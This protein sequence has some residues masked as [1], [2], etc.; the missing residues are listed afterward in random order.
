MKSKNHETLTE[1]EDDDIEDEDDHGTN[2]NK[3]RAR[4]RTVTLEDKV[5]EHSRYSK[6]TWSKINDV[7]LSKQVAAKLEE[8]E[9]EFEH[10]NPTQSASDQDHLLTLTK[11]Q[12]EKLISD[13][14]HAL[15][16]VSHD[17]AKVPGLRRMDD[18]SKQD[19]Q[20][21]TRQS[22]SRTDYRNQITTPSHTSKGNVKTNTDSSKSKTAS[23]ERPTDAK[24]IEKLKSI[25]DANSRGKA[26]SVQPSRQPSRCTSRHAS[27]PATRMQIHRTYHQQQTKGKQYSQSR[28]ATRMTYHP[29][30]ALSN[31]GNLGSLDESTYWN[32]L[33]QE[34][35]KTAKKPGSGGN[36][37]SVATA[38]GVMNSTEKKSLDLVRFQKSLKVSSGWSEDLSQVVLNKKREGAYGKEAFSGTD[39]IAQAI[40]LAMK[41][42]KPRES[43]MR[44]LT[45]AG[46][47]GVSKAVHQS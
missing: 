8:K 37:T 32:E 22:K 19:R 29:N 20:V 18:T 3:V 12:K 28:P 40:S 30:R 41:F 24:K 45:G 4:E 25:Y 43:L 5:T 23:K 14:A 7:H 46:Q 47:G 42:R 6:R 26:K 38:F 31:D 11:G 27:R 16:V 44:K 1:E 13:T 17:W 35:T 34:G 39:K 33:P 15:G 36:M 10:K 2:T 9:I 21:S